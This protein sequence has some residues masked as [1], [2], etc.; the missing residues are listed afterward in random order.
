MMLKRAFDGCSYHNFLHRITQ[1]VSYHAHAAGM[2]QFDKHGNVWT[3]ILECRVRRMPGALP[4]EN[5]TPR[6]DLGPFRIEGVTAVTQPFRAKLPRL[7]MAAALHKQL[8]M[9]QPGP[10]MG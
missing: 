6:F 8:V 1:K 2:R 10:V 9:A 7:A 5:L 3:M 4:A